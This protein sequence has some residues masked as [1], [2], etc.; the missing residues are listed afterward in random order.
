MHTLKAIRSY[1][2]LSDTLATAG[3]PSLAQLEAV[4]N[5][6]YD[7]ALPWLYAVVFVLLMLVSFKS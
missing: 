6:G 3:Q 7:V 1:L 4:R 5:T 2:P